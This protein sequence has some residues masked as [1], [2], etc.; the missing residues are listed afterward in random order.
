M[1]GTRLTNTQQEQLTKLLG[2]LSQ[3]KLAEDADFD[4][5]GDIETRIIGKLREP[6]DRA[7]ALSEAAQQPAPGPDPMAAMAMDPAAMDPMAGAMAGGMPPGPA[8]PIPTEANGLPIE[9]LAQLMAAQQG[10]AP[11][12]GPQRGLQPSPAMPPPDELRRV[13]GG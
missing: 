5:I 4:F 11:Q 7:N 12:A 8:G 13:L 1:A 2:Q 3:L 9:L 6:I 10:G